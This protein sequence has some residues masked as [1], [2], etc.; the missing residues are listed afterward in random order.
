MSYHFPDGRDPRFDV[1]PLKK[2]EETRIGK[3]IVTSFVDPAHAMYA[4]LLGADSP[5]CQRLASDAHK[6]GAFRIEES[7]I[8]HQGQGVVFGPHPKGIAAISVRCYP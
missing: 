1:R 5:T 6:P 4:K 3:T 2:G 7:L 8:R